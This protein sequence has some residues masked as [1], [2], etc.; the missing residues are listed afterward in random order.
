M[1]PQELVSQNVFANVSSLVSTLAAGAYLDV[2]LTRHQDHGS[3]QELR[4]LFGSAAEL[5]APVDD[6]EETARQDGW[7]LFRTMKGQPSFWYNEA[8]D[9]TYLEAS[10]LCVD[11]GL[12]T[13]AGH[14]MRDVQEH[15]LVSTWLADK[16]AAH[17]EKVDR[18]FAGLTIWARTTT[19]Q[20]IYAD[21]VIEA[22]AAEVSL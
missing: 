5:A 21:S 10:N 15:R 6:W 17:G 20:A 14:P 11:R 8:S 2:H 9:D 22:I 19:G 18:D 7:R 12:D 4:A 13:V 3:E 1:T 16:L